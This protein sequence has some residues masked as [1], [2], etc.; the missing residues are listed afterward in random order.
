MRVSVRML[1]LSQVGGILPPTTRTLQDSNLT[2]V[3]LVR[4]DAGYYECLATSKAVC[5]ITTTLL[6]VHC[7]PLLRLFQSGFFGTWVI[8]QFGSD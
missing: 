6:I 5:I 2:I 4:E 8:D 3:Q 1:S 7:E